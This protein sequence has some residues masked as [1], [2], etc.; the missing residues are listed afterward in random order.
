MRFDGAGERG[1]VSAVMFIVCEEVES[2]THTGP[3]EHGAAVD[4]A[5]GEL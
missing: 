1:E 2:G 4:R 3:G 5:G